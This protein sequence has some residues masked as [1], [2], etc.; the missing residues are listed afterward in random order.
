[1]AT[2]ENVYALLRRDHVV[3]IEIGA[4]LL[5]FGEVL[6][7]FERTLR[8]KQ[9]LNEHASQRGGGDAM[10]GLRRTS[11]GRK[12]R[13]PVGMTVRVA[14]EACHAS[15]R[16]LRAAILGLVELLRGKGVTRR[17]KPS[18]CLG[19]MMPLNS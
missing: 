6:D 15:A 1:M 7:R 18:S 10:A 14:I 9:P 16:L 2:L 12:M 3:T 5:E 4:P 17:R 8:A 11:I 19:L 13:R